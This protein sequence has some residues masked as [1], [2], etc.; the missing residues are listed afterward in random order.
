MIARLIS[1]LW[2]LGYAQAGE[3]SIE[4]GILGIGIAAVIVGGAIAYGGSLN[5][6]YCH[7]AGAFGSGPCASAGGGSGSGSGSGSGGGAGDG[8]S[9][10]SG[11]GGPTA[12]QL[13]DEQLLSDDFS[14]GFS[15][16]TVGNPGDCGKGNIGGFQ[17]CNSPACAPD[18]YCNPFSE[19]NDPTL[20]SHLIL[21]PGDPQFDM[22]NWSFGRDTGAPGSNG[23]TAFTDPD[24]N[25]FAMCLGGGPS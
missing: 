17:I 8:G 12:A 25:S 24:G 3:A 20:Y 6:A 22:N 2:R 10:S 1:R 19:Q 9:G 7:I 13:A 4:Y 23:C 11:G 15:G 21:A 18:Q 16:S 5:T 14:G